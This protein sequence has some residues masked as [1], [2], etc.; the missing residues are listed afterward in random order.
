MKIERERER[1]LE[2]VGKTQNGGNTEGTGSKGRRA[3]QRV[4]G[5]E[6]LAAL[7]FNQIYYREFIAARE[8]IKCRRPEAEWPHEI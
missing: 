2:V 1:G 6:I 4:Q 3:S 7:S 5:V 8:L